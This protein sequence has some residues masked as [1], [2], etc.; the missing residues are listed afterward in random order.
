[1]LNGI[2]DIVLTKADI[3]SGFEDIKV[4]TA[5]K[6][7]GEITDRMPFE[8]EAEIEPQYLSLPGWSEDISEMK[9]YDEL[10]EN[11]KAY[12]KYIEEEA[13]VK[14]TIISVGPDRVASIYR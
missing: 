13:N 12:I 10:P 11:F 8:N 4:C 3:L 2:T 14:V 5:Y 9:T 1:M 6:V 7:N